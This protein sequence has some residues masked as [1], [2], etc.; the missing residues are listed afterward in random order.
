MNR[1]MNNFGGRGQG[2]GQNFE[3]GQRTVK[4]RG[5]G[6]GQGTGKGQGNMMGR[7]KGQGAGR[8]RGFGKTRSNVMD[9]S[10][11][12]DL[13]QLIH[14]C[15]HYL[16]QTEM[17]DLGGTQ[18]KILGILKE[19]GSLTQRELMEIL[20]VKAGSLSE[21]IKKLELKGLVEKVPNPY[22]R[23]SMI[24]SLTESG[25]EQQTNCEGGDCGSNFSSLD[26]KQK[27]ELRNLLKGLLNVWYK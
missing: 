17:N 23:R 27:D 15:S 20:H 3:T 24:I 1:G 16:K 25:L 9:F 26:D 12:D 22:D 11:T 7:G 5:D 6:M 14:S 13:S 2:M 10:D 19:E 18:Q 21:I 8:G 4:G